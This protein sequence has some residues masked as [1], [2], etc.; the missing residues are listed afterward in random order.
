MVSKARE[1]LPLPDTPV[2]TTNLF[3]G[4][5]TSMFFKL[6]CRAPRTLMYLSIII[7]ITTRRTGQWRMT[8]RKT[9]SG[10]PWQ[11]HYTINLQ[12][13]LLYPEFWRQAQSLNRLLQGAFLFSDF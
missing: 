10:C 13:L 12:A 6:C 2:K 1:L 9:A 4:I 8:P 11:G 7:I 5:S 3:L